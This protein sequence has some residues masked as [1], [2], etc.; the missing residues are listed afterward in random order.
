MQVHPLI[1]KESL[2]YQNDGKVAIQELEKRLTVV[3]MIGWCKGNIFKYEF[4]KQLK[5]ALEADEK[6]IKTYKDYLH[7]LNMLHTKGFSDEIVLDAF[8]QYGLE[9]RY[10]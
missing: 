5:G 8:L 2:H 3:E 4:R 9:F 6:K 7:V 1:N 10:K